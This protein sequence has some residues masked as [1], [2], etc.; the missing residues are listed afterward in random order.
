MILDC[1]CAD[2]IRDNY[3]KVLASYPINVNI[4]AGKKLSSIIYLFAVG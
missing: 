1:E 3:E 2:Y 4:S